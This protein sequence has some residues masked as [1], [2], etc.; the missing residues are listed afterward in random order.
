VAANAY[1]YLGFDAPIS[2]P[3]ASESICFDDILGVYV[4][5]ASFMQH[6]AYQSPD[7]TGEEVQHFLDVL[8]ED[9]LAI[10]G[11]Y[12]TDDG[13]RLD[14]EELICV[15]QFRDDICAWIR[16]LGTMLKSIG[17][18]PSPYLF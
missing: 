7:A 6:I 10:E 3:P 4:K 12:D 5:L 1:I 11:R 2:A 16:G 8:K 9:V 17:A 18:R 15:R 13:T 14:A